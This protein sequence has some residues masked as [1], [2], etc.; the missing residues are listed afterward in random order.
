MDGSSQPSAIAADQRRE[1]VE[2]EELDSSPTRLRENLKRLEDLMDGCDSWTCRR[3]LLVFGAFVSSWQHSFAG[4]PIFAGV[5]VLP[6]AIRLELGNP[7]LSITPRDWER[8]ATPAITDLADVWGI[9][10]REAG[11]AWFEVRDLPVGA[12]PAGKR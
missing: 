8:L 9:D 2:H 12:E 11:R 4:L 7:D 6:G 1:V 3:V 5:T 10:R